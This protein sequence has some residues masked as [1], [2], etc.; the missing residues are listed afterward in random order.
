M[1]SFRDIRDGPWPPIRRRLPTTTLRQASRT[2]APC[3]AGSMG[4]GG[5]CAWVERR[6]CKCYPT[7]CIECRRRFACLSVGGRVACVLPHPSRGPPHFRPLLP[8]GDPRRDIGGPDVDRI[9][10]R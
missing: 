4:G 6:Y 1:S 7:M 9:G 8:F 5:L 10:A 2:G 3:S